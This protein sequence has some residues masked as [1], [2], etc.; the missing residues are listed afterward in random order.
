MTVETLR[1]I[2]VADEGLRADGTSPDV[3][4]G[5]KI[6]EERTLQSTLRRGWYFGAEQFREKLLTRLEK[7]K[8][9]DGKAHDR[10]S[11]YTGA[12]AR[13]HG[14]A[15]AERIIRRGL[16]LADLRKSELPGLKKGD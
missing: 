12:Q 8:G 15:E 16:S 13:D 10:R 1:E 6:G 11:G 2:G 14:E 7:L 3:E 5:D 9:K 4:D